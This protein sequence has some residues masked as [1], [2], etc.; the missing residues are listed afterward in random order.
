MSIN[1]NTKTHQDDKAIIPAANDNGDDQPSP[2]PIHMPPPQ[3]YTDE[4]AALMLRISVRHFRQLRYDCQIEFIKIGRRK[5]TSII[6]INKF[7]GNNTCHAATKDLGSSKSKLVITG[8]SRTQTKGET[9]E[10]SA[11]T[12]KALMKL[13]KSS[14]PSL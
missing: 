12:R 9:Q 14:G 1:T 5:L 2:S 11:H 8:I 3:L 4:E 13:R 7:L 6:Q 10:G